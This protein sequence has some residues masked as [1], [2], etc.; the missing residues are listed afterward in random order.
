[1]LTYVQVNRFDVLWTGEQNGEG[2]Q[3]G[4]GVKF[5]QRCGRRRHAPPLGL[6]SVLRCGCCDTKHADQSQRRHTLLLQP[7]L[8]N[9]FIL[10]LNRMMVLMGKCL[11][12]SCYSATSLLLVSLLGSC[13]PPFQ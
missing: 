3:P 9:I 12:F 8:N 13:F 4:G 11:S 7:A 1:M 6:Q 5:L 10:I 2:S